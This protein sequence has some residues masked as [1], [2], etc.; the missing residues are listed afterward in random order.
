V[1]MWCLASA[2]LMALLLPVTVAP[3]LKLLEQRR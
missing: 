1:C 2:T 3:G